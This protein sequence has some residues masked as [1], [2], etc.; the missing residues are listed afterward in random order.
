MLVIA[1]PCA[2]GLATPAAI[3]AG[4]GV[5]ATP[6]HPD[7]GRATRWKSRT[8][9]TA[10]AFDKT[11]TL[12]LGKPRGDH[13]ACRWMA[14]KRGDCCWRA[15]LPAGG[16]E[17]PLAQAPC[18]SAAAA[19]GNLRRRHVQHDARRCRGRG[20]RG[21]VGWSRAGAWAA[22]AML[23]RARRASRASCWTDPPQRWQ[24]EGAH[25]CPGCC[26]R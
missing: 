4:T 11:G 9:V 17:H 1:C 16:S 15:R 3:M 20:M 5:A 7:Q 23:R 12:T 18:W 25:A 22:G 19:D 2:L 26:G 24:A 13:T 8:A 10:V 14:T 21:H 6:R